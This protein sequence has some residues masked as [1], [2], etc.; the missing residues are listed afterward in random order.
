MARTL[1]GGTCGGIFQ[2]DLGFWG[3][4]YSVRL[5]MH[6]PRDGTDPEELRRTVERH[7]VA[8]VRKMLPAY[9]AIHGERGR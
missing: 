1:A 2:A 8:R 5:N 7:I 3:A 9:D 6:P 4:G